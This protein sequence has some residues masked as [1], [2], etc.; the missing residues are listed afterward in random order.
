[1]FASPE[2]KVLKLRKENYIN[3]KEV[4]CFNYLSA[5]TRF[6]ASQAPATLLIVIPIYNTLFSSLIV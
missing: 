5:P 6:L 3:P 2:R 4:L 1:M